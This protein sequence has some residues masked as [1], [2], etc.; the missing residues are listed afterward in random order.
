[1]ASIGDPGLLYHDPSMIYCVLSF[2]CGIDCTLM[3]SFTFYL[4]LVV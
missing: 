1:M 2:G 4:F 3:L